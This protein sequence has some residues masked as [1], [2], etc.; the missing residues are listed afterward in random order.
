MKTNFRVV[1]LES[2]IAD[3]ARRAAANGA[4]DHAIIRAPKPNQFPC[5][6]CL[7]WAEPGE[8]MVLFSFPAIAPGQPYSESGPIFV[9]AEPCEKYAQ[10]EEFPPAFRNGRAVRAYDS[11]NNLIAA[12]VVN[13]DGPEPVIEKLL[14]NPETEFLHVRS[15]SHGCYTMRIEHA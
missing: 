5:R 10:Q 14:Q 1:P 4:P 8:A 3:A 13:G 15:A 9:H 12:E 7:Q 6:H 11:H 2:E